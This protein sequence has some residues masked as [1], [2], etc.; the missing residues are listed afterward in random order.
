MECY[1]DHILNEKKTVNLLKKSI[2]NYLDK[3]SQDAMLKISM[4]MQEFIFHLK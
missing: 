2:F 4:E 3:K 1:N